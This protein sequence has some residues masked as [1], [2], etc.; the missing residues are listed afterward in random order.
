MLELPKYDF[1]KVDQLIKELKPIINS[2]KKDDQPYNLES[3][4]I[5]D[6]RPFHPERLW[7]VCHKYLE[8]KIFRSKGFSGLL[9]EASIHFYGIKLEVALVKK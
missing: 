6:N 8:N 5:K 2:E 7:E 9:A 3:R 1:F 4:V